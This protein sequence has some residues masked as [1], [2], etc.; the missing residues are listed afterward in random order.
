[1]AKKERGLPPNFDLDVP[2]SVREGPVDLGDYLDEE[3]KQPIQHA[4]KPTNVVVLP[5]TYEENTGHD[6]P[7]SELHKQ[8]IPR[9]AK[10]TR[11]QINATPETLR[12]F[13]QLLAYVRQYGVQKD[14]AASELFQAI[15]MAVYEAK[16]ELDLSNVSPRGRWGTPTARAFPTALK[17]AVQSAI[18]NHAKEEL[19]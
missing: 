12:V 4:S 7:E 11:K 13:E 19:E 18:V 14:T 5:R 9:A 1:M 8:A 10:L 15:V 3:D 2:E 17:N 6:D 16:D